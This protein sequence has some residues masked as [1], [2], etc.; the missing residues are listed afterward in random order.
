MDGDYQEEVYF[1]EDYY[2]PEPEKGG[3]GWL[4]ALIIILALLLVCCICAFVTVAG[5]AILSPAIEGT[6]SRFGGAMAAA[7]SL[8]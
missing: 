6:I 2:E 7:A 4:I 5:L 3:R 1:D 8:P